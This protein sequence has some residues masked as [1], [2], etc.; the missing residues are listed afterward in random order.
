MSFY[1]LPVADHFKA[2]RSVRQGM[3][4]ETVSRIPLDGLLGSKERSLSGRIP[5]EESIVLGCISG[6]LSRSGIPGISPVMLNTPPV[7]LSGAKHLRISL[8]SRG[9]CYR[10]CHLPLI[11]QHP[12]IFGL[13]PLLIILPVPFPIIIQLRV[14]E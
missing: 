3:P 13:C 5:K 9:R 14:F 2:V 8:Y 6:L 7:M 1:Y 10:L 11:C 4:M 12:G